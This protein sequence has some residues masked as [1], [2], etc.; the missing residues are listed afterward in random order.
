MSGADSAGNP[1]AD[2]TTATSVIEEVTVTNDSSIDTD[3]FGRQGAASDNVN[4]GASPGVV[5]GDSRVA[6]DGDGVNGQDVPNGV[7]QRSAAGD[8]GQIPGVPE[9][10]DVALE[11]GPSQGSSPV[12]DS[13]ALSESGPC[14]GP[15]RVEKAEAHNTNYP[16]S[17]EPSPSQESGPVSNSMTPSP[18]GPC[19]RSSRVEN[20]EAHNMNCHIEQDLRPK[21]QQSTRQQESLPERS[22]MQK[23][24]RSGYLSHLTKLYNCADT[25]MLESKNADQVSALVD[26]INVAYDNVIVAH[27]LYITTLRDKNDLAQADNFLL[28]LQTD[29]ANFDAN[30]VSWFRNIR[31]AKSSVLSNEI[32]FGQ[33]THGS[34]S[35]AAESHC[36]S[37]EQSASE[38]A[39][40][41]TSSKRSSVKL[42]QALVK[43]AQAR[44]KLNQ[45]VAEQQLLEEQ[46]NL[47]LKENNL[48]AQSEFQLAEIECSIWEKDD[49]S[50]TMSTQGSSDDIL[51]VKPETHRLNPQAPE[52]FSDATKKCVISCSDNKIKFEPVSLHLSNDNIGQDMSQNGNTCQSGNTGQVM[53][54]NGNTCQ[55]GNTGQVMSQ[56]GNTC[57]SGNTGQVM[58]QNGNTC[59]SGNTGQVMSQNGNNSAVMGTYGS[60]GVMGQI[61]N[62]GGQNGNNSA[63]MGTYGSSGVMGQISNTGGQNGN[64]SAVMGTY[65]SSG[66]MGQISNT[67]GQNGN[68][69]AVMGTYGS[70]GVMGQIGNTGGQ[71]GNISTPMGTHG[72]SGVMGQIG[73]TGGQN[74]NISTSMGTYGSV[75]VMGQIGNTGVVVNQNGYSSAVIGPYGNSIAGAIG[76]VG[77]PGDMAGQ[78]GLHSNMVGQIANCVDNVGLGLGGDSCGNNAVIDNWGGSML[79]N[80]LGNLLA[81][82]TAAYEKLTLKFTETHDRPKPELLSFNGDPTQYWKFIQ[83]FDTNLGNLS[84]YRL[85][86]NYLIQYCHGDARSAIEDCVILEAKEGYNRARETLANLYGRPH[87]ISRAYI[88]SLVNGPFLKQSDPAALSKLALDMQKC[89]MTLNQMGYSADLNN[90]EN[91]RKLV[92]RLPMH[93]RTRWVERADNLIES[94]VEPMFSHLTAFVQQRARVANSVYGKDLVLVDSGQ[95]KFKGKQSKQASNTPARRTFATQSSTNQFK[96]QGPGT[97]NKSSGS[98][99]S[100]KSAVTQKCHLCK[101]SHELWSCKE[102]RDKTVQ[103]RREFMR[104]YRLC[105]NCA[106]AGHYSKGCMEQPG[107]STCKRKHNELLHMERRDTVNGQ[108]ATT[109]PDTRSE[110]DKVKTTEGKKGRS[111]LTGAG[112]KCHVNLRTIPVSVVHNGR[113]FVT[114]ALLDDCSDVTLCSDRLVQKLGLDGNI[115]DFTISTVN[116]ETSHPAKE[117]SFNVMSLDGSEQVDVKSAWS[118]TKIP[119]RVEGSQEVD[120]LK[121]SHLNDITFPSIDNKDIDLLIGA[122]NPEVFWTIDERRGRRKE[123]FAVKT[124]LGWSLIGPVGDGSSAKGFHTNFTKGEAMLLQEQVEKLWMTDFSENLYSDIVSMSV[125][126]KRAL[127]SMESTITFVDGHYQLALPW[128]RTPPQ[129]TTNKFMAENRLRN[130]RSRFKKDPELHEKY[131]DIMR[132][133]ERSGVVSR[134]LPED[135]GNVAWYIPHHPVLNPKKPGKVRVVFDCAAKANNRSLNEELLRGP[136]LT[137]NLVGVLSRF[138]EE[139]VAMMADIRGMFNQVMV[140]PEDR[141]YLGFLW[142][143]EGELTAE[144]E[145]YTMNVHLFGATS[146]PSCAAFCLKRTAE[147]HKT[148]YSAETIDAVNRS[149]NVDDF[150]MSVPDSDKAARLITELPE[151]LSKGGFHLAKW[152]SNRPHLLSAIPEADCAAGPVTLEFDGQPTGERAL[153]IKWNVKDD[154][155][156]FDTINNLKPATRRGILSMVSTM[157][158]PLGIVSPFLLPAKLLLQELCRQKVGWDEKIQDTL[159]QQWKCWLDT[160]DGISKLSIERCFIPA[161]LERPC[162]AE[163][164]HFSDASEQG[165][166]V[167]SY[168]RVTDAR[169]VISCNIAMGKSRVTPLKTVSI[170][171][172]E[173]TAA[174][175][176]VKLDKMLKN[177]LSIPLDRSVFWTDSTAVLQYLRNDDKRFQTFVANRISLIHDNTTVD[178]WRHIEGVK[179]PADYASRGLRVGESEKIHRWFKGPEFLWQDKSSWPEP[180][181]LSPVSDKDPE[182]RGGRICVTKESKPNPVKTLIEA[183]SSWTKLLKSVAWLLRLKRI[184]RNRVCIKM[185]RDIPKKPEHCSSKGELTLKELYNAEREVIQFVQSKSFSL[186]ECDTPKSLRKLNPERRDGILCVKGRLENAP[187]G[188][189]LRQPVILPKKGHV[190]EMVIKHYHRMV[191]HSGR[192]QT[193]AFIRRKYWIINGRTAVRRVLGR[194]IQCKK[195]NARR[196]EQ[197]M[198]SLP[199]YRVT[200]DEP[201]FSDTGIDYFGP[202]L[203]KRARSQEKRYGCLFTCLNSRAV[204]I[205]VAHSLDTASFLSA[206]SRFISRRGRPRV[207]HSDNGTNFRGGEKELREMLQGWN[208]HHISSHLMQEE[209]QWEF[210]PPAASHMG[211]AWERLIRSIKKILKAVIGLQ[212]LTDET[213]VTFL[214]ETEKILNDRPLTS[215]SDDPDDL[216]PLT[217]NH[218]LLLRSNAS[219]PPGVFSAADCYAVRRWRQAQYLANIFWRRWINEYMLTLQERQKWMTKRRNFAVGDLVLVASDNLS[220]G[221][222]PLGRIMETCPDRHGIVRSAVVRT[223]TG[224]LH[225]PVTCLCLLEDT[226]TLQD[227]QTEASCNTGRLQ[228]EQTEAHGDNGNRKQERDLRTM[229]MPHLLRIINGSLRCGLV[230]L[231]DLVIWRIMCR[232]AELKWE[233]RL[234]VLLWF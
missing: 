112:N 210:N 106:Q 121:W 202:I 22:H 218:V 152:S 208:Q 26:K 197:F 32:H 148:S 170:P 58:S 69:S 61:S 222:W 190:T 159:E 199:A 132:D 81:A 200:P 216:E 8:G 52:W 193:L 41:S 147:D 196:G 228:D 212:S 225:R 108:Q 14:Q 89:D 75:G 224:N 97:L 203:V 169:G 134:L 130:L 47:K 78:N 18:C 27:E 34:S 118:I 79:G 29:K 232:I 142:W 37:I 198:A 1:N 188:V 129:L 54:Q 180:I 11:P 109:A 24:S 19:Q 122:D 119:V 191:G 12:R 158:D 60:S 213:L 83:N 215:V 161:A 189:E 141:Q 143:P 155:F 71:N 127:T 111:Y 140:A 28:S 226:E 25:L 73:N 40:S 5:A 95:A 15:S 53:S 171:R 65:G 205:E 88:D 70:S 219:L 234:L 107:C 68:N 92:R 105:D 46:F 174:T 227:E 44:F 214:A 99:M 183:N 181:N 185:K 201:P 90:S 154:T 49:L 59:Q 72:S 115:K 138:R 163:L 10:G 36:E 113:S 84:D 146:S 221:Q 166:G 39:R 207:L 156:E 16:M 125:E 102:F 217:P 51:P 223:A 104:K 82:Q 153:G 57:Q 103:E 160:L 231:R 20:V 195:Q 6:A 3:G 30:A 86:L 13:M 167:V 186:E 194:C 128:K 76:Q 43:R 91:L 45:L 77:S 55:S 74:G 38:M 56:N 48:K 220:R 133:Y 162:K 176:A 33:V 35:A 164:H 23:K 31:S 2:E 63:V 67:G 110:S 233:F 123:P 64:N 145:A 9:T 209:I 150:L 117:V 173:L 85:R 178:Q 50:G 230:G 204:H 157:F 177:E 144:P 179:N 7:G 120:A 42:K 101:G 206:L 229:E 96:S 184:L 93:I 172:L 182:V 100:V 17:A 126:D 137:N 149:S 124:I 211:G 4:E 94:G 192:N 131:T 21:R 66:V 116:N 62:T 114:N 80:N 87:V 165:Y 135:A 139:P 151:L 175:T 187:I 136:D 98:H 168:V